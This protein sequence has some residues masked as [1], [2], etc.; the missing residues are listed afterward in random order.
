MRFVH[1]NCCKRAAGARP[2]PGLVLGLALVV[3]A[4]S[5]GATEVKHF[6]A[7]SREAF[8]AGE[9]SGISVDPL[10]RL[11]LA[12]RA[13][14]L[15]ALEEPF[16]FTAA[17]HPEGWV[18][19]TGNAGKVLLVDRKG[20][21]RTLF[22]APESEIF[23]VL[24]ESDGTVYAGSS[25]AGKVYRIRPGAAQ[26]EGAD[27]QAGEVFFDPEATYIWALARSA[28]G[29][30]L[31]ATGTEGKL[32]EVDAEGRGKVLYDS[33]DT[34]IR[35]LKVLPGGDV[36]LGT[37][38]EG[39]VLRLSPD[40]A[41]ADGIAVRTLFD[42]D[43]PEVVALA[44]GPGGE[45]YAAVVASEASFIDRPG[46]PGSPQSGA[47]AAG[48]GT[49]ATGEPQGVVTVSEGPATP[50][51]TAAAA[52][53]GRRGGAAKKG[54]LLRISREGLVE[55]VWTFQEETVYTLLWERD[56]L[57]V[58]TGLEGKLYS[59]DG[60]SLVLEKDVD[61]RQLVD[62]MPDT[63]GPAFVTTNAAA[64]YRM[65]GGTERGGTYTSPALD[66]GGVSRFGTLHWDGE[67][68][69][70]SGLSFS[71]RSGFSAEP[72]R[73]WSE[74][75]KPASGTG[76]SVA[77]VSLRAVPA[78][79]YV[80]WRLELKAAD[81]ASPRLYGVELS[82]RQENLRPTIETFAALEA[83]QI[84]VPANFN[85]GNQV[86]EPAHPA[87][88][89]IFTTLGAGDPGSDARTKT[90]WK[91]GYRTLRWESSDPNG[92][93]LRYRLEFRRAGSE[94]A[95]WLPVAE[96]LSET[97]LS[98]DST[99]VPDGLYRFRLIA[100]DAP[101]NDGDALEATQ[102]SEPILIDHTP[103][104]LEGMRRD[105][106]RLR[107]TVRDGASPLSEAVLSF[108]AKEWETAVSEDGLTDG[109]REVLVIPLPEAARL[110]LLRLTDAAFNSTTIDLSSEL[111]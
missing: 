26:R 110:L 58:G 92:D 99:V 42:A 23:A 106:D 74:W 62:L 10:G 82:Y 63:P 60:E 80:Q 50:V 93:K 14:R 87:R 36:L 25:P 71:F 67:A 24:A 69:R 100:S 61:E 101:G 105:G 102:V 13:E 28:K 107:V 86:Y 17:P 66:A 57:W 73:T 76:G 59:W 55:S 109:R 53:R 70:G 12:D 68:P 54:E 9:L 95:P 96:D 30:L 91:K 38:E 20:G 11:E 45:C 39:L 48:E 27:G 49:A 2:G 81:G 65:T 46:S 8:L 29:T 37:A 89:G 16:V 88:D 111:P 77:E 90:L 98:F 94:D 19:G 4:A 35:S 15:S 75:S 64:L 5:A 40:P 18:V 56:R 78:G 84:L 103:P 31:V 32:F 34:H 108:D 72:D 1:E 52:G 6:Q 41:A 47:G 85:P 7:H 44:V 51:A 104:T 21:V 79:R 43:E 3:L 33:D 97:Y 22:T 83:G